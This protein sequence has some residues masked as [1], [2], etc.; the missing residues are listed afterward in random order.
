MAG[1]QQGKFREKV[2]HF[3]GR[4]ILFPLEKL[5]Q[6]GRLDI[7]FLI[8][9]DRNLPYKLLLIYMGINKIRIKLLVFRP[10]YEICMS[11]SRRN[12]PGS[13]P[14]CLKKKM[15]LWRCIWSLLILHWQKLLSM[16][17]THL[18]SQQSVLYGTESFKISWKCQGSKIIHLLC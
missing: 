13:A 16:F 7:S 5:G 3:S 2:S 11:S 8:C 18:S 4:F 9:T 15:I 17:L 10:E 1:G 14:S 6:G 12:T